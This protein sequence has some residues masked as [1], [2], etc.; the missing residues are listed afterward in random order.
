MSTNFIGEIRMVG[1]NFPPS[2]WAL[3]DGQIMLISQNNALFALLGTIYGGDGQSTF[4]LPNLQGRVPLHQGQSPGI[5]FYALGQSAGMENVTMQSN[6][7]PTHSHLVNCNSAGGNQA[8]PRR[9]VARGGIDRDFRQLHDSGC[10]Q[11]HEFRH[12]RQRRRKPASSHHPALSLRE[13]HH[14]ANRD[15]PDA[16]LMD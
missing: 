14:R 15:L 8:P 4:A 10:R 11:H 12:D 1:F 2:G 5:S 7:M 16:V 13:F 9:W 3:C 6:Q